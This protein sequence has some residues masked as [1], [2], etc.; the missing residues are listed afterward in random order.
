MK[1]S[2]LILMVSVA[3]LCQS[4]NETQKQASYNEGINIIPAPQSMVVG[5]G[6]FKLSTSTVFYASTAEGRT[7]AEF[8]AAKLRH[9]TGLPFKIA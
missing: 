9:S 3:I 6:S 7:V 1:K 5:E 8:F 4:C 2:G